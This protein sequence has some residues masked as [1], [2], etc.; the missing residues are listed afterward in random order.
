[1]LLLLDLDRFKEVND[2]FS[3]AVGDA[4]LRI[5]SERLK[6]CVKH[7][8]IVARLGGDEFAILLKSSGASDVAAVAQRLVETAQAQART[9]FGSQ[10]K[11]HQKLLRSFVE[12]CKTGSG[13]VWKVRAQTV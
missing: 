1:M 9:I 12:P 4:L 5:V 13:S 10:V 3:H 2:T 7:T 11:F 6:G 8:D